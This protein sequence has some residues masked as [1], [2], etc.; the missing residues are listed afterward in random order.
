V[1][2]REQ[3]RAPEALVAP[4]PGV[5]DGFDT[6]PSRMFVTGDFKATFRKVRYSAAAL[7]DQVL[8]RDVRDV[9]VYSAPNARRTIL[10][11]FLRDRHDANERD[12]RHLYVL[13]EDLPTSTAP[14]WAFLD[15]VAREYPVAHGGAL[16]TP[17]REDAV[18]EACLVTT[19]TY[20]TKE[21]CNRIYGDSMHA[22]TRNQLRRLY[23]VT[24]IGPE[25]WARLPPLPAVDPM[26]TVTDLG[27]C[28]VLTAWPT[29]VDCHDPQF[30]LGTRELRRWLWPHTIQNPADDPDELDRKLRWLNLLP[31]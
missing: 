21:R 13:T 23:P 8:S 15:A 28:K 6:K 27:D 20:M 17:S 31:G 14:P 29:L 2:V 7:R 26:P 18:A 11:V 16:W 19:S 30:L 3:A 22:D 25:I 5:F 12:R 9:A 24:I 4:I 10:S 1:W